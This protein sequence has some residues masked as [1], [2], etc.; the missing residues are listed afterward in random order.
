MPGGENIKYTK[1]ATTINYYYEDKKSYAKIYTVISIVVAIDGF[2]SG[3]VCG[4]MFPIYYDF[5]TALMSYIWVGT[6]FLFIS[7]WAV[8]YHFCNQEKII[9][10]QNAIY[11]E[12]HK[13]AESLSNE[14]KK[15]HNT[16]FYTM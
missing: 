7:I 1:G 16:D 11:S 12:L 14:K 10:S 5:N 2:I 6:A 8:R 13:V 3:I 4:K 15:R 9:E